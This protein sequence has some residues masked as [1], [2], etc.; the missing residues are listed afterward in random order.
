M[1]CKY[2]LK[3]FPITD[4]K[5]SNEQSKPLSNQEFLA[6]VKAKLPSN[7]I[8]NTSYALLLEKLKKHVPKPPLPKEPEPTSKPPDSGN[9]E[10][11]LDLIPP[12]PDVKV[13]IDKL[14]ASVSR[15]GIEFETVLKQRNDS[16]C[17]II[18][19]VN[20]IVFFKCIL[21]KYLN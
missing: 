17:F 5:T 14:A 4:N 7:Q 11:P 6:S 10:A 8:A 2:F 16:R 3:H 9:S 20:Y 21:Q 1:H 13:I 12:P 15:V 19:N 18:L